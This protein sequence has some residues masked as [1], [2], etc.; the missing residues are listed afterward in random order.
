MFRVYASL[1]LLGGHCLLA[2]DPGQLE[3][4]VKDGGGARL[5]VRAWVEMNGE[6]HF[7]PNSP[8]SCVPYAKDRSFSCDGEFSMELPPGSGVLHVEKGKEWQTTVV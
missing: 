1:L 6:Q 4:T 8:S 5:P 2:A 3:V 7:T